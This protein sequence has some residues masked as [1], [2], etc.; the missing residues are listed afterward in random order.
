[1]PTPLATINAG[2][3]GE[4]TR[5][6][7]CVEC[8]VTGVGQKLLVLVKSHYVSLSGGSA[9]VNVISTEF[10]VWK[11]TLVPMGGSKVAEALNP[12]KGRGE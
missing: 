2:I 12:P 3:G 4:R 8:L 11:H 1:V 9:T 6:V 7:N 10:P 5:I